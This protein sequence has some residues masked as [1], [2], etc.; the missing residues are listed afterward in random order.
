MRAARLKSTQNQCLMT[1]TNRVC[2]YGYKL[3]EI[4]EMVMALLDSFIIYPPAD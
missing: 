1:E 2:G 3:E 4:L